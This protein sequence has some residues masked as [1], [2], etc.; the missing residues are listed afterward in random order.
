MF[1]LFGGAR[2]G[3]A[4]EREDRT[5]YLLDWCDSGKCCTAPVMFKTLLTKA[6]TSVFSSDDA[7]WSGHTVN[8]SPGLKFAHLRIC[9]N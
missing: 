2:T 7:R 3:Y 4:P 8:I 6:P 1:R 9:S 5:D